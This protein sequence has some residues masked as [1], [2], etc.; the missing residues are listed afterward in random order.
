MLWRSVG[1][2]LAVLGRDIAAL[3]VRC[4]LVLQDVLDAEVQA[5]QAG[6][7]ARPL[8][9]AARQRRLLGAPGRRWRRCRSTPAGGKDVDAYPVHLSVKQLELEERKNQRGWMNKESTNQST[10]G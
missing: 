9:E 8:A 3:F 5:F 7:R 10:P 1:A 4:V 6:L 2:A